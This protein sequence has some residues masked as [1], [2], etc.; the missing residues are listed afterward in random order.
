MTAIL[1]L[2]NDCAP[3]GRDHYERWYAREHIL[4]RVDIPGFRFGR[5]FE[6]DTASP[7]FFTYYEVDDAAVLTSPAYMERQQN[8]TP[9]TTKAMASFRNMNRTVCEV[10]AVAG[11][12]RGSHVVTVRFDAPLTD[13]AG[14]RSYVTS[15]AQRDGVA[16]AHLWT[17]AHLQTPGATREMMLRDS[18]DRSVASVVAIEC[19]RRNDAEKIESELR[20]Q[21]PAA[22]V[23]TGRTEIGIYNFLCSYEGSLR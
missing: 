4:E 12:L 3:D 19:I 18:P 9:A 14:A 17:A 13:L 20:T 2:W 10:A 6:S 15:I 7:R 1:V 22:L 5:R 21:R 8:P 23:T 16:R 11:T